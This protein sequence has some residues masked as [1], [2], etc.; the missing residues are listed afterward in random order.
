MDSSV[1]TL[2]LRTISAVFP[3]AK[4]L[5]DDEAKFLW[6]TLDD[7]MKSNVSNEMWTFAVKEYLEIGS[8]SDELPLHMDILA[9]IYKCQN[10][11]PDINW[12]LKYTHDDLMK[13]LQLAPVDP[14]KTSAG[15]L[16]AKILKER[17]DKEFYKKH[18]H[19]TPPIEEQ[20]RLAAHAE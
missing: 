8:R 3:Y 18:P 17:E 13:G 10:G 15:I 16:A 4:K 7:H 1:F 6:L 20:R 19:L 14:Y 2:G 12:G 9:R 11:R 5:E